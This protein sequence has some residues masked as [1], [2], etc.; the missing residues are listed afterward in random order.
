MGK[1]FIQKAIKRPGALRKKL[2]AKKGK[3]ISK[4]KLS[5]AAKGIGDTKRTQREAEFAEELEGFSK[6]RKKK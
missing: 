2:G 3:D 5:R 6:K 4:K 1:K